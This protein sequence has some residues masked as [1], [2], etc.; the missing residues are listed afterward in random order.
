MAD[1]DRYAYVKHDFYDAWD[2]LNSI[3]IHIPIFF[4]VIPL[5]GTPYMV[6]LFGS[7]PLLNPVP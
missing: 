2:C 4:I 3:G 6:S 5:D 1:D 7:P